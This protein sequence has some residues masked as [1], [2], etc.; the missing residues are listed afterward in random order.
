MEREIKKPP[1]RREWAHCPHCGSKTVL[2]DNT[3][4]CSGVYI[5]CTRGCRQEFELKITNGKQVH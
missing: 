4:D 3:S 1:V 2:Y 5:K